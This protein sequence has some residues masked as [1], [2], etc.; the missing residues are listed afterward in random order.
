MV[1]GRPDP[2][3][4]P[5][6]P[7]M[8]SSATLLR[9]GSTW[10][11]AFLIHGLGG[12][13]E[14]F[15]ELVGHF[16]TSRP[17][18]ALRAKGSDGLS[19]PLTRVEKMALFYTGVIRHVQLEGPYTIIGYSLGGLVGME[20]ARALKQLGASVELLLMVD[21]YP[22]L[23]PIDLS[24]RVSQFMTQTRYR[25]EDLTKKCLESS[26][27]YGRQERSRFSDFLALTRYRP[28]LYE[29]EI[30]FVR[31]ADSDYPDPRVAWRGL[32]PRLRI[33]VV[34]GD[35]HSILSTDARKLGEVISSYLQ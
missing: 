19:A 18:Y 24:E 22:Y 5:D 32:A 14:E 21:S 35:H 13:A 4:P 2:G 33:A 16:G 27:Q 29:G 6:V 34:P 11:P 15:G 8:E 17:I 3:T 30:E 10:P 9:R 31:A 7:L 12:T 1:Y 25:L 28:R 26:D 20:M 23:K